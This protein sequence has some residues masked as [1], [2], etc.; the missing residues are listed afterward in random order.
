[1]ADVLKWLIGGVVAIFV[2]WFIATS[3]GVGV[4]NGISSVKCIEKG[5]ADAVINTS[6]PDTWHN[7]V[8]CK[9]LE[10]GS[11]VVKKLSDL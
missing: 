7:T 5:Y 3:I 9:K 1:M 8:Y 11:T 2:T 6:I 10:N 4:L